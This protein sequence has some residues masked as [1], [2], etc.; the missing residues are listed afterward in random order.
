VLEELL[1]FVSHQGL[2][3]FGHCDISLTL[4]NKTAVGNETRE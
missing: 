3:V 2:R 1:G 4:Y